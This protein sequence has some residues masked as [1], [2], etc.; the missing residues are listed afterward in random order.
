[1][2]IAQP[3]MDAFQQAL[4]EALRSPAS[5]GNNRK[6]SA[7]VQ[8][9]DDDTEAAPAPDTSRRQEPALSAPDFDEPPPAAPAFVAETEAEHDE[10]V[11]AAS[12]CWMTSL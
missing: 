5:S 9:E 11:P 6:L 3:E 2:A 4:A 12:M 7:Y 1:M 10:A 8:P